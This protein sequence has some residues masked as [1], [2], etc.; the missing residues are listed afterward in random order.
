MNEVLIAQIAWAAAKVAVVFGAVFLG[1]APLRLDAVGALPA[2]PHD[3]LGPIRCVVPQHEAFVGIHLIK[4]WVLGVIL[5]AAW[6]YAIA[7]GVIA[8]TRLRVIV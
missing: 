8:Q 7:V 4:V 2:T 3:H 5:F 6:A 1:H